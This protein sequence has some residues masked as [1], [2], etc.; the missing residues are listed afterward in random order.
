M[1]SCRLGKKPSSSLVLK[2]LPPLPPL[3]ATASS[4]SRMMLA[5]KVEGTGP[6]RPREAA[7]T[8]TEPRVEGDGG[9][10]GGEEEEAP[11]TAGL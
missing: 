2:P 11:Y 1:A 9:G 10:G 4:P 6:M 7:E 8:E 3:S 5:K